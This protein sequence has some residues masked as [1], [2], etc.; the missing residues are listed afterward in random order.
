[1]LILL[2]CMCVIFLIHLRKTKGIWNLCHRLSWSWIRISIRYTCFYML[3]VDSNAVHCISTT[4]IV[5]FFIITIPKSRRILISRTAKIS[6][7]IQRGGIECLTRWRRNQKWLLDAVFGRLEKWRFKKSRLHCEGA[8]RL[9][10]FVHITD[11]KLDVINMQV[12][13]YHWL[14]NACSTV[15]SL[16]KI[17]QK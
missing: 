13:N 17:V 10:F 6:M 2:V 8:S 11:C 1:M 15:F 5:C 7:G 3:W 14:R 4:S 9:I 12:L 16:L